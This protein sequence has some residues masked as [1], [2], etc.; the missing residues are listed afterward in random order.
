MIHTIKR[1]E[2]YYFCTNPRRFKMLV[3]L[4]KIFNKIMNDERI[5]PSSIPPSDTPIFMKSELKLTMNQTK[6]VEITRSL[7]LLVSLLS[8]P[9]CVCS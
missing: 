1:R 2:N 9:E 6:P 7:L 8:G 4:S 5:S 3:A